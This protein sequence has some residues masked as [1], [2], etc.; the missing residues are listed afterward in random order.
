MYYTRANTTRFAEKGNRIF[1]VAPGSYDTPMF[2]ESDST[3]DT[4]RD[5]IPLR[6]VG[7]P[8]EMGLLV[9]QLAGPGHDY[10][11]GTDILAD[12]GMCASM[13]TPQLS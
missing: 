9:A 8:A 13:T 10:L 12:G 7:H 6:R 2:Q 5:T 1:S 4:I 3:E 11:T